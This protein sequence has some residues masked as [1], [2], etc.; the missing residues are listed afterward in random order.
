MKDDDAA[1]KSGPKILPTF[2]EDVLDNREIVLKLLGTKVYP[3]VRLA[4]CS[5]LTSTMKYIQNYRTANPN[6]QFDTLILYGHGSPGSIN[7][8]TS[9]WSIGPAK[10]PHEKGY[11]N[12]KRGRENFGL[13][14]PRKYDH[15]DRKPLRVRSLNS[16]T[17]DDFSSILSALRQRMFRAKQQLRPFSYFPH[18]L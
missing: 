14:E 2:V 6:D 18:G 13:D 10:E 11:E 15:Q 7:M 1:S 17:K 16:D 3:D 9:K 12:R 5:S 8:G 4:M